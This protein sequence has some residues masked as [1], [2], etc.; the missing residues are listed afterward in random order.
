MTI[1]DFSVVTT[2]ST[3]SL[4]FPVTS[5]KWPL[6]YRWFQSM[7][8]LPCYKTNLDGLEKLQIELEAFGKFKISSQN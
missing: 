7:K 8:L 6:L 2:L 4:L 1:A 5:D 3:T